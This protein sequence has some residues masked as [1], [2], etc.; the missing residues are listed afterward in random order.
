MDDKCWKTRRVG[1]FCPLEEIPADSAPARLTAAGTG[2]RAI[3]F[4]VEPAVHTLRESGPPIP[5]YDSPALPLKPS[6]DPALSLIAL[7]GVESLEPV[8]AEVPLVMHNSAFSPSQEMGGWRIGFVHWHEHS[9]CFLQTLNALRLA[10]ALLVPVDAR[11]DEIDKCVIEHR[12]DALICQESSP[13]FQRAHGS[14]NP[15]ACEVLEDGTRIWLYG[16]QWAGDRL[17]CLTRALHQVLRQTLRLTT[18]L[19][20]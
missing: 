8:M 12:L 6:R 11:W 16:A 3:T 7:S 2:A 17:S 18:R 1:L 5:G 10:G 14:S 19:N 13:A 9:T 20:T 4:G 15:S